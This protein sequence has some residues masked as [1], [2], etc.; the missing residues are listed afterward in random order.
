MDFDDDVFA[1]YA[2]RCWATL[3]TLTRV[4]SLRLGIDVLSPVRIN[5]VGI[6][7]VNY[8]FAWRYCF[9][10]HLVYGNAPGTPKQLAEIAQ[11]A[12]AL[13]GHLDPVRAADEVLL[14]WPFDV[15]EVGGLS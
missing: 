2:E 6:S 13:K 15:T 14:M 9:Y 10:A 12:F 4:C 3:V 1:A 8:R 5:L 11:V 7:F